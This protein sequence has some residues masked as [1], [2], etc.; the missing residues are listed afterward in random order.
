MTAGQPGSFRRFENSRNVEM[1]DWFFSIRE[2]ARAHT[3]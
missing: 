2:L 3:E 1:A